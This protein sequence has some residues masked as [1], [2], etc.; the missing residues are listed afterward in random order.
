ME[1]CNIELCKGNHKLVS[2]YTDGRYSECAVVRWC[3]VCGAIVI[4]VDAD[5]RTYPGRL[6]EMKLPKIAQNNLN[7]KE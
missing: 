1:A 2:I 5:G 3:K 6:M 4:D 7:K